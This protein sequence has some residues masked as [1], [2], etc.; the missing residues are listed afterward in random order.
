MTL[1]NPFFFFFFLLICTSNR[2][3][4]RLTL[5]KLSFCNLIVNEKG[6]FL[7]NK[8]NKCLESIL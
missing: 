6:I 3:G 5:A 2:Q 1:F 8:N 4:I 7:Y